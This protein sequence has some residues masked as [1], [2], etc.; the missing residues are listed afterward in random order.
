MFTPQQERLGNPQIP[1]IQRKR[2]YLVDRYNIVHYTIITIM[3]SGVMM[4]QKYYL[5]FGK[6]AKKSFS[7]P[8]TWIVSHFVEAEEVEPLP[9]IEQMV[10]DALSQP[11]AADPLAHLVSK[12]HRIAIIV[13]DA[14]RPTPVAPI[15]QTLLS[16]IEAGG[17]ERDNITIVIALGTH[18]TMEKEALVA[19]MGSNII[20]RYRVIQHN[21]WQSDL[22]PVEIPGDTRV[23][24]INPEV[25][26]ADLR[27][28][29]SSIL[30]H[31]MAGYGGGPKIVMPGVANFEFIRDHHMKHLLHPRS[32]AGL[33]KGNPFHEDCM[34]AARAIRLDFSINCVY[35]Q[36]GQIIRIIGGSMDAA[37]A[38]A[39]ETC[40]AKL[41]H[42]FEEK[43]DITIASA[44]P[45][46]H[47][48]QFFKGLSAPDAVTKDTGAILLVAPIVAPMSTEF[49][50]SFHVIE[51]KSHNNS[52]AYI[53]DH[54]SKGRAYLPDKSID[55]NM[56]MSTPF[57][58]PKIRTILVSPLISENQARVM[59]LE[60]A[61]SVE[62][63]LKL[64][65]AAYTKATVAIFPAGGLIIP[66]TVWER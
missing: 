6:D 4:E 25:A 22:V 49:L 37:F 33:T 42:R 31:P 3:V 36:K 65:E 52:A 28:G 12:A 26:R 56:A 38:Q 64:L 1:V 16:Q 62:E 27:I 40:L 53:K 13:D 19:R 15:L 2:R 10:L 39:V 18:E 45:H 29:I 66:I 32:T 47:G 60:Y 24:R 58:R 34:R 50:N 35:D 63:G 46:S 5:Y 30:P 61:S 23:L 14:T 21:A 17:F 43:V 48:H 8:E 55:F 44:Y 51:E 11:A 57:L 7:L 54:L 41:G 59:G 9:S 20:A